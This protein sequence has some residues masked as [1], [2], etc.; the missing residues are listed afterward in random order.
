MDD[1]W[2]VW[3]LTVTGVEESRVPVTIEHR[4]VVVK[5]NQLFPY[6]ELIRLS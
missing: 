5:R 6:A 2:Y 3:E 4:K 1:L